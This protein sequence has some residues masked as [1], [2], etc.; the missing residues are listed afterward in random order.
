MII[1]LS[2]VIKDHN[3]KKEECNMNENYSEEKLRIMAVC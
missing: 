2:I 3:F 1:K